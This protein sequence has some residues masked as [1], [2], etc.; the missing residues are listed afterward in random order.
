A[1]LVAVDD[2]RGFLLPDLQASGQAIGGNAV[3]DAEVDHFG[4]A[5]LFLGHLLGHDVVDLRRHGCVDVLS[6]VEGL[7]EGRVAGEVGQ[8]TQLDLRVVGG[9]EHASGRCDERLTD[10]TPNLRA[11][12]DVLEVGVAAGQSPRRGHG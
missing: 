2:L 6:L 1:P 9:D 12:G 7:D 8:E 5:A 3:D 10:F 11:D 4:A